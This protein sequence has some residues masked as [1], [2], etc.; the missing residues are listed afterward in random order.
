MVEKAGLK[1]WLSGSEKHIMPSAQ[2]LPT[3]PP[4]CQC[5]ITDQLL[6]QVSPICLSNKYSLSSRLSTRYRNHKSNLNPLSSFFLEFAVQW[7]R[8]TLIR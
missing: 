4:H 3:I 5:T 2:S 7:E 8:Q 6:T 1:A